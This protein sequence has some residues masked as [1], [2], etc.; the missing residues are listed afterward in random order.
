MGLLNYFDTRANF[1][2]ANPQLCIAGALKS[3]YE[4]DK[5]KDK[6]ESSRIMWA[7]ALAYDIESKFFNLPLIERKKFISKDYLKNEKFD[8]D[9]Y[10]DCIEFYEKLSITPARRQLIVW[11]TKLDEKTEFLAT[12]PYNAQNA[13]LIDELLSSNTK[14]YEALAKIS[15]ELVKEGDRGVVKGGSEESLSEKGEL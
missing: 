11:N 14:L 10:K 4:N 2:K 7:I 13:K 9:K 6:E 5:S 15:E 8:F 3:L 12:L 1:W